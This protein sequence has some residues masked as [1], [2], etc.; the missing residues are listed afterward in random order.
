MENQEKRRHAREDVRSAVMVSPNGNQH[1]AEVF[2]LSSS[3]VR[4]GLPADFDRN[5]G[6]AVRMFFELDD[7]ETVVLNA[8]VVRVAVDHLGMEFEPLQEQDIQ[9][10]IK[11]LS[12]GR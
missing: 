11:E 7:D 4:V 5:V 10:L 12:A 2:N 8:H 9:H 1:R 6:A 3:G